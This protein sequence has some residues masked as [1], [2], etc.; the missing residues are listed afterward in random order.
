MEKTSE[1]RKQ[2]KMPYKIIYTGSFL[3]GENERKSKVTWRF[4][5]PPPLALNF[6]TRPQHSPK[7]FNLL[8]P[9]TPNDLYRSR[10][11]SPLKIKIPSKNIREKQQTHQLFIQFI[12]YVW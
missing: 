8:N 6:L 12:N 9:L 10:A 11:V 5:R 3:T 1:P 2:K 4:S 7:W